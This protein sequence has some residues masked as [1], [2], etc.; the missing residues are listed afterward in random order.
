[1]A[2]EFKPGEYTL[3]CGDKAKV[4]EVLDCGRIMGARRCGGGTWVSCHWLGDGRC[5]QDGESAFD[6]LPPEPKTTEDVRQDVIK[7][8]I[9]LALGLR[10][11]NYRAYDGYVAEW[12]RDQLKEGRP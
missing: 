4:Y 2:H 10:D 9:S 3:R 8:L 1:M 6:L 5:C 7:E 12:L 11:D